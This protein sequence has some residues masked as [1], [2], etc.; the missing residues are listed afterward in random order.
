MVFDSRS[1]TRTHIHPA[2]GDTDLHPVYGLMIPDTGAFTASRIG[3]LRAATDPIYPPVLL[4]SHSSKTPQPPTR[5]LLIGTVSNRRDGI[6]D[7]DGAGLGMFVRHAD[8]GEFRG[9]FQP[10]GIVVD[11]RGYFCARRV[12]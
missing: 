1:S 9:V 4:L 6:V 12:H 2:A 10:W 3:R 5:V 8:A 7:L 11:D